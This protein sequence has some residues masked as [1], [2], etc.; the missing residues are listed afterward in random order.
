MAAEQT[1]FSQILNSLLSVDNALRQSAEVSYLN[2]ESNEF[3]KKCA[4]GMKKDV[5]NVLELVGKTKQKMSAMCSELDRQRG[6]SC[7]L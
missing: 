3:L 6:F 5:V 4:I 7:V 2:S 1:D